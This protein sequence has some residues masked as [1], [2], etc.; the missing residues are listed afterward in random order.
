MTHGKIGTS[1]A[2]M[3]LLAGCAHVPDVTM[4]Y[5][6]PQSSATVAITQTADC[7]AAQQRVFVA[8]SATGTVTYSS[9]LTRPQT[10]RLK[11]AGSDLADIDG[12]FTFTE[13]GRL[14]GI[15]YS[16]TGQGET[17]LKS[18]IA[19]SSALMGMVG[20]A[21][22]VKPKPVFECLT[23]AKAGGGKPVTLTYTVQL[24]NPIDKAGATIVPKADASS[25]SLY[26]ALSKAL[27]KLRLVVS[28]A[29]PVQSVAA[30]TVGSDEVPLTLSEL[31]RLTVTLKATDPQAGEADV[32]QQ[33]IAAP[34]RT[35][36]TLPI[37]KAALFGKS[38][39]TLGLAE[40]GAV[41]TIGYG[42]TSGASAAMNAGA[43]LTTEL[44]GSSK[45][46]QAAEFKAQADFIA[47]QQRLVRCQA[48][49]DKCE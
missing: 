43:A 11:A 3:G 40:S 13:D 18:A 22:G 34:T 33:A 20:V 38:S 23:I 25:G 46:E 10:F 30:G 41:T 2:M 49:P 32:W 14:K 31:A 48:N 35:T 9:D 21:G 37:S 47:Q 28:D 17:I 19:L 39:F 27:P 5:Y 45:V 26:L 8:T 44:T 24:G 6:L 7:D 15:S 29:I 1:G 4:R 16:S 12:S 42:S 36:Y